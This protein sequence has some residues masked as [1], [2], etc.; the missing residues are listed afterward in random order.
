MSKEP[1]YH[2]SCLTSSG[3]PAQT[4]ENCSSFISLLALK[5]VSGAQVSD[6]AACGIFLVVHQVELALDD[7]SERYDFVE[8]KS[9]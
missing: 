3:N 2:K 8:K 6:S 9:N 7:I 5:D 4:L 1:I